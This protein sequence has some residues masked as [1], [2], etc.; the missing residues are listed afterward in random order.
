MWR[1]ALDELG[2]E[3]RTGMTANIEIRGEIR[4]Q[5]LAIPVESVFVRGEEEMV[6]VLRDEPLPKL[7]KAEGWRRTRVWR[8]K[9]PPR[10][11]NRRRRMAR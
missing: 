8:K 3:L 11:R 2:R 5:V 7:E 6:Y 4:E 10:S 1:S 9:K